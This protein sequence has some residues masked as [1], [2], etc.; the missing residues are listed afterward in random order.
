MMHVPRMLLLGSTGRNSGKTLFACQ[1]I[2]ALRGRVDVVGIKVTAIDRRDG[3]CPRGGEGCGVCSSLDGV[4]L[5]TEETQAGPEK[6]TQRLLAAGARRVYW[7]RVLK[8][9]LKEG[10]EALWRV[11]DDDALLVCESNTLRT[12]VEPGLFLMFQRQGNQEIKAS[13]QAVRGY[14]DR[15]V[16]FDGEGFDLALEDVEAASGGWSLK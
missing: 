3:S 6:D 12:A 14:V 10:L 13:A 8:A 7:L 5:V 4:Y 15:L 11:V 9:S 1:L 16:Q 2:E